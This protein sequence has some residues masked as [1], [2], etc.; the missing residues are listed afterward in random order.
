LRGYR[1][2][3]LLMLLAMGIGVAAVLMLTALGEGARQYVRGEF[4]SLGTHL[5]I[6]IPGR[7]ETA[8][9]GPA[10]MVGVTPRDLTLDDARALARHP[11]IERIA[12]LNVG[13]AEISWEGRKRE[14][15]VWGS[16]HDLL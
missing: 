6:V 13:A 12:P 4:S 3:T 8:G 16:T 11:R 9:A 7:S 1:S 5:V 14:V 2:R 15:G 10:T